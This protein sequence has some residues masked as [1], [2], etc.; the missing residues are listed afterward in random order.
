MNDLHTI[1]RLN[2]EAAKRELERAP[3]GK[4]AVAEYSGIHFIKFHYADSHDAAVAIANEINSRGDSSHAKAP[5]ERPIAA[6]FEAAT[7]A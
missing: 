4:Y 5:S 6:E 7:A 3:K 2:S 1:A